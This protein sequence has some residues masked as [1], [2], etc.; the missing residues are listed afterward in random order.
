MSARLAAARVVD[1]VGN[2]Q[3]LTRALEE[4]KRQTASSEHAATQ[5]LAYG[6]VRYH[7]RLHWVL[8]RLMRKR[9]AP[10]KSLLSAMLRVGLF[11]LMQEQSPPHAIVAA[12]VE[13]TKRRFA[14]A[15]GLANA[16]L[17]NFQRQRSALEKDWMQDDEARYCVPSRWLQRLR[18]DWPDHWREIAES[19]TCQ[20]KMVVRVNTVQL[21]RETAL[22]RFADAGITGKAHP[23]IDSAIVLDEPVEVGA[24]PG[25]DDGTVSVQDGAA[26]LAA[27]LLMLDAGMK[28]LDACAAPGGKTLHCLQSA[29]VDLLALDQSAER[30][31][32]LQQNLQRAGV[33]AVVAEADACAVDSWWDGR[34]FDRVLLDAPCSGSGV[35]HRH[36]DI[37]LHRTAADE[38]SM[39]QLQ[40]ELLR[41]LWGV[42]SPGGKMLYATCSLWRAENHKQIAD[43]IERTPDASVA[44]VPVDF[45]LDTP[46]GIQLLPG[47]HSTDGFFYALIEKR[48]T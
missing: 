41:A 20:P 40:S 27:P 24:L 29:P 48:A 14:W 22:R 31:R 37:E 18:E 13:N 28:V 44:S 32:Q 12:T 17:R 45:A 7:E 36:P 26:Q 2:G 8:D 21:D 43:F 30:L 4:V 33:P 11:E 15:S 42:L 3:S 6:T 38:A 23:N 9:L 47:V 25:F 46:P 39:Q 10:S 16:T 34:P 35:L 5:A 19:A 1:S